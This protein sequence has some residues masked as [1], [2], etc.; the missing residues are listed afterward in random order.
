FNVHYFQAGLYKKAA[1]RVGVNTPRI[2]LRRCAKADGEMKSGN[3]SY[4]PIEQLI[5]SSGRAVK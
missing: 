3:A 4:L 1:E 5:A 2:L